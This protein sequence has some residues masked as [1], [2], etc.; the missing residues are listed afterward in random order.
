MAGAKHLTEAENC[1]EIVLDHGDEAQQ[2]IIQDD[3]MGVAGDLR[4][5]FTS[6][7]SLQCGC[8]NAE[9][10]AL[11]RTSACINKELAKRQA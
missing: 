6:R 11:R 8:L 3:F 2:I 1:K 4:A 9:D 7:C 5:H 10:V